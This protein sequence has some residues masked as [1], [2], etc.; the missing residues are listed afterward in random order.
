MQESR[1]SPLVLVLVLVLVLDFV[2]EN[3]DEDEDEHSLRCLYPTRFGLNWISN[4]KSQ[5]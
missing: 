5:I 2:D 1:G 3:E 4:P